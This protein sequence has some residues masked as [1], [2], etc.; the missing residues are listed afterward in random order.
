MLR[1]TSAWC[2][3]EFDVIWTTFHAVS[4]KQR[5]SMLV[6]TNLS[7][8]YWTYIEKFAGGMQS[9]WSMSCYLDENRDLSI[10]SMISHHSL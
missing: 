3:L 1:K 5:G 2:K 6:T 9:G 4:V 10:S 7:L 8:A